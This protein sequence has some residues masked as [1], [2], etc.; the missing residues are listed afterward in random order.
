MSMKLDISGGIFN[1]NGC[2][3]EEEGRLGYVTWGVLVWRARPHRMTSNSWE[4]GD[5]TAQVTLR[6]VRETVV[7]CPTYFHFWAHENHDIIWQ[8]TSVRNPLSQH[9]IQTCVVNLSHK[10][11]LKN[12]PPVLQIIIRGVVRRAY[13]QYDVIVHNGK[14]RGNFGHEIEGL[15]II[16]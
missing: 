1:L 3:R 2:G 9:H 15:Q 4:C 13:Q 6:Q 10:Y 16:M 5:Q 8:A 12:R 7:W 11:T 14:R